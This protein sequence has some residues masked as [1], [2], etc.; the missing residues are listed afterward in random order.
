MSNVG[1]S[2]KMGCSGPS[3]RVQEH[4]QSNTWT[5]FCNCPLCAGNGLIHFSTFIFSVLIHTKQVTVLRCCCSHYLSM[6]ENAWIKFI[7]CYEWRKKILNGGFKSDFACRLCCL[8]N[9]NG[10]S[11]F[12]VPPCC[13][14]S[15]WWYKSQ[16][17]HS[18]S[19]CKPNG[20]RS[21]FSLYYIFKHSIISTREAIGFHIAEVLLSSSQNCR[22]LATYHVT[23]S[24]SYLGLSHWL[25]VIWDL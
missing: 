10:L 11:V 9:L 4:T 14:R 16:F 8:L 5:N 15:P 13:N 17:P 21:L 24:M 25:L 7:D 2:I 20:D 18:A 1:K 22:H 6:F 23:K 3:W 19:V 12:F